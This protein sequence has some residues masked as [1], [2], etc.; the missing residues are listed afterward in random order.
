MRKFNIIWERT[1]GISVSLQ[2][3]A[4]VF[5]QRKFLANL[6]FL[7]LLNLII[8]PVW[9]FGIDLTVQNMVG[10]EIYGFYFT[11][12]NFSFLFNILFDFGITNFNNRNIAQNAQLL[13]K[14]FS[15]IVILKILLGI[16]YFIITFLAA[17]IWGY[18]GNELYMLLFLGIN[19]FLISF[20]LYL[21]SNVSALLF[22]KT[23]SILSVL[24]RIVMIAICSVLLWGGVTKTP[25]RIEWFVYAQTIA[26]LITF[27]VAYTVVIKKA[28]FKR[29]KWNY[30]FFL[31]ILKQ[32]FPYALLVLLMTFYNKIDTVMLTRLIEGPAGKI[33]SGIYAHA[34]R[35]LDAVNS[36]AFLFSMLLLP[37]FA[38]L[39][40][41]GSGV[42]KILKLSFSILFVLSV[43]VS[44]VSVVFNYPIMQLLYGNN[45]IIES[46]N[47]F[48]VL[49]SSFIAMSTSY[50]FGTLLTANGNLKQLNYL[51]A[52][53]MA[54]NI[55]LNI[56]LIP[57]YAAYGSAWASLITQ[58]LI[59][60]LQVILSILY[61][62]IKISYSYLTKLLSFI[63]GVI[64]LGYLLPFLQIGWLVKMSLMVAAT[65]S[66]AAILKLLHLGHFIDVLKGRVG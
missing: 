5:M 35:L 34:Y 29:F 47:L 66:L 49:M 44:A 59:S 25:F 16:L 50:V 58:S 32:S 6:S 60:A 28:S 54:L 65:F 9:I 55:S 39:I 43:T 38:R 62:K 42:E 19:Q 14:H 26:Y 2:T 12:F 22:F 3:V 46:A 1:E 10:A 56:I 51:A 37:L 41:I 52:I 45:H 21:R 61:L 33:Q 40:K 11:L 15:S 4:L 24:D 8:K 57:K 20:I 31:M 30:P 17:I 64:L 63:A 27:L 53:G 48:P 7:L 23:D 13:N 36:F 18:R